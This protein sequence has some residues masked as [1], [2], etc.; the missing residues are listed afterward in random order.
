M[1]KIRLQRIGKKN[2]PHFR[3]VL[4]E[5]SSA[6]KNKALEILGHYNPRQKDK[7]FKK[8]R[9]LYWISVGAQPSDTAFNLL[10]NENIVEGKKIENKKISKRKREEIKKQKEE[11]KKKETEAKKAA[12]EAKKAEAAAAEAAKTEEAKAE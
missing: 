12:A 9:I 1:L 2:E 11:E 5:K 10:H 8:D 3:L 4:T 7:S 6:V